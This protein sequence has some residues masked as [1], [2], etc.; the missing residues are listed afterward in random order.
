MSV[1]LDRIRQVSTMAV[2][3]GSIEALLDG[4]GGSCPTAPGCHHHLKE[5]PT[6][7]R[8][9]SLIPV[10]FAEDPHSALARSS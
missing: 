7:Y 8:I 2:L 5:P 9:V 4:L 3:R 10:S 1:L 6:P